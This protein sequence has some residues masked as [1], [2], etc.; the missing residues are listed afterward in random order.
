MR[1]YA[2]V[3]AA[4]DRARAEAGCRRRIDELRKRLKLHD[5]WL[6][7]V[8]SAKPMPPPSVRP[9]ALAEWETCLKRR[10]EATDVFFADTSS[11]RYLPPVYYHL[12]RA[13]EAVGAAA[14]AR[15]SYESFLKIRGAP[16]RPTRSRRTPASG[17]KSGS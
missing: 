7:H 5:S 8:C 17:S 4:A 3:I 14:G 11:L 1:S 15:A 9:E 12:A 6:A 10:G 16:S 13:Q 2:R